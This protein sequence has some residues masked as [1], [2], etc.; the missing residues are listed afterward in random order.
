MA[1]PFKMAYFGV[2]IHVFSSMYAANIAPNVFFSL[3][4][5]IPPPRQKIYFANLYFREFRDLFAIFSQTLKFCPFSSTKSHR[6]LLLSQNCVL[7]IISE[8]Q[9]VIFVFANLIFANFA[10]FELQKGNWTGHLLETLGIFSYQIFFYGFM[11][12]KHIRID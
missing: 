1:A 2:F 5:E 11:I 3:Q 6:M 12:F 10:I 7:C 4:I 8:S 9:F